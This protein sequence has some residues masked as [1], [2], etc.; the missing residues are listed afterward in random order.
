MISGD[1]VFKV[2]VIAPETRVQLHNAMAQLQLQQGDLM[3]VGTF[4]NKML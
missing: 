4:V 2:V 3:P 1:N